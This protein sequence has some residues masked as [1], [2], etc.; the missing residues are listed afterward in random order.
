MNLLERT[1]LLS[2]ELNDLA[3]L[4][5]RAEQAGDFEKRAIDLDGPAKAL[6]RLVLAVSTIKKNRIDIPLLP[7]T[8]IASLRTQATDI[9]R[10]YFADKAS[11]LEPNQ[12]FKVGITQLPSKVQSALESGWREWAQRQVPP[13]D[14]VVLGI[15]GAI[16]AL[17]ASVAEIDMLLKQAQ[18]LA[19][20]LPAGV[21]SVVQISKIADDIRKTSREL[22]GDGVPNEVLLFLRSACTA[23][24]ASYADLSTS[25]LE[26]LKVHGLEHSL[27]IRMG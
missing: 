7:K 4:R 6:N 13:I 10:R 26:W 3:G 19:K 1:N 15:L 21:E 5:A 24:G 9:Q 12:S 27:R 8:S 23:N 25:V 11:I 14:P 18:A 17:Q 20:Q 2:T 22:T 16:P